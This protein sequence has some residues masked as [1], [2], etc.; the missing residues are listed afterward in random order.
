M[1]QEYAKYNEYVKFVKM[2][3]HNP[4]TMSTEDGRQRVRKYGEEARKKYQVVL[5]IEKEIQDLQNRLSK[6]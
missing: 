2:N 5:N 6:L 3:S 4:R 1:A